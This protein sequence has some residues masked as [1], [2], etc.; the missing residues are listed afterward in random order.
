MVGGVSR[1]VQSSGKI[2]PHQRG[3]NARMNKLSTS[4]LG[5]TGFKVSVLGFGAA[6]A[7]YLNAQDNEI[8]LLNELLDNGMNL[9]DTA[10][11]YP[12]S[13]ES[14]GTH[15]GKRRKDYVLVSK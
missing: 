1:D 6:P 14:I 8:K 2:L 9:I 3:Y 11:S 15:F 7:A 12:G 13:E 10:A 5:K 4:V